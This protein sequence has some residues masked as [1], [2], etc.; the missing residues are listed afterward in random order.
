[1][2]ISLLHDGEKVTLNRTD[3]DV[4]L[5]EEPE[6]H[7]NP[8]MHI[9]QSLEKEPEKVREN[10]K[11][12]AVAEGK[13]RQS[14]RQRDT[15]FR[16]GEKCYMIFTD[17]TVGVQLCQQQLCCLHLLHNALSVSALGFFY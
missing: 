1:M 17:N 15:T 9:S 6:S 13:S 2:G 8:G 3:T 7:N 14:K 5:E 12:L 10:E 4:A 11:T 16:R